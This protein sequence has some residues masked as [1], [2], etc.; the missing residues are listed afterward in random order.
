M[1]F[2]RHRLLIEP[3]P[4]PPP[5][6]T[7]RP[8]PVDPRLP[9][10]PDGLERELV[11]PR[12]HL[13]VLRLGL[14]RRFGERAM[15]LRPGVQVAPEPLQVLAAAEDELDPVVPLALVVGAGVVLAGRAAVDRRLA[16]LDG[17]ALAEPGSDLGL[18]G[19]YQLGA[20]MA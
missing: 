19:G 13:A 9:P 5:I 15:P 17:V 1:L 8:L 7:R 12:R 10:I 3:V 6:T 2:F 11:F 18:A 16:V 4:L 14:G 20:G